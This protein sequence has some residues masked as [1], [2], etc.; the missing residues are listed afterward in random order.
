M[1]WGSPLIPHWHDS[2]MGVSMKPMTRS[3]G[4]DDMRWLAPSFRVVEFC[5]SHFPFLVL[6]MAM[7]QR[8]STETRAPR[9]SYGHCNMWKRIVD[10]C[11]NMLK[12]WH[13]VRNSETTSA[14][15]MNKKS[16]KPPSKITVGTSQNDL[17]HQQYNWRLNTWRLSNGDF[18]DS[19]L[20][21]YIY[22]I[23]QTWTKHVGSWKW[24]T[25]VSL[26]SH[27]CL[28]YLDNLHEYPKLWIGPTYRPGPRIVCHSTYKRWSLGFV[29]ICILQY[30]AI[31]LVSS[32]IQTN[33]T[34]PSAKKK[35]A[36]IHDCFGKSQR[37]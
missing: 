11:W 36:S 23:L 7:F 22:K 25:F 28:T 1:G 26:V 34:R 3:T 12:P 32:T 17:F 29:V 30:S 13:G 4:L 16:E 19:V 31:K 8:G 6:R 10:D 33:R 9:Y 24:P 18:L 15:Q 21:E 20:L 2:P 37:W 35:N 27:T 5:L 14:F